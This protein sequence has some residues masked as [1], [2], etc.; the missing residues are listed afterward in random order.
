MRSNAW[1]L[2]APDSNFASFPDPTQLKGFLEVA[3]DPTVALLIG[4]WRSVLVGAG[5][6]TLGAVLLHIPYSLPPIHP[7]DKPIY[8]GPFLGTQVHAD[9][10]I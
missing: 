3:A 7:K 1:V 4:S 6:R 10:Q 9:Q 8:L 5:A 2:V